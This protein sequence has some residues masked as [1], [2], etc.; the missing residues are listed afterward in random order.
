MYVFEHVGKVVDVVG[1]KAQRLLRLGGYAKRLRTFCKNPRQ[2]VVL[3]R[4]AV[5]HIWMHGAH[6]LV[7]TGLRAWRVAAK[8]GH[9]LQQLLRGC[10]R[11]G[12]VRA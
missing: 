12:R 11:C 1:R 8:R 7:E 6:P 10:C 2:V 4:D 9:Q 3:E 5:V